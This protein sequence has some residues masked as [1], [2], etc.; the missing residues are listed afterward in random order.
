VARVRTTAA[1]RLAKK[2]GDDGENDDAARR[3]RRPPEIIAPAYAALAL[4]LGSRALL[5]ARGALTSAAV[6]RAALPPD[7]DGARIGALRRTAGGDAALLACFALLYACDFAPSA[8]AQLRCAGAV[9]AA[10]AGGGAAADDDPAAADDARRRLR[11]FEGLVRLK[12]SF[13][14]GRRASTGARRGF[15]G[16]GYDDCE[17]SLSS[18]RT[19]RDTVLF[20]FLTCAVWRDG[21]PPPGDAVS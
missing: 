8:R 11:R 2:S 6:W 3:E 19:R 9:R 1:R 14:G 20:F 18:C 7:W 15:G 4:A 17:P 10:A 5:A 13:V 16:E 21:P 12:V